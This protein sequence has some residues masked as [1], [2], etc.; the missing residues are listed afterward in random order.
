MENDDTIDVMVEREFLTQVFGPATKITYREQRLVGHYELRDHIIMALTWFL[1]HNPLVA[2]AGDP[3]SKLY[4]GGG[5][6]PSPVVLPL[7]HFFVSH[8][9][10]YCIFSIILTKSCLHL[11]ESTA[12]L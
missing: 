10:L 9:S 8:I 6:Q 2:V 4:V 5:A 3:L 1:G 7:G 11:L 12:Y